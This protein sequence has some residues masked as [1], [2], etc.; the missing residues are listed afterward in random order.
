MEKMV[1]V[2]LKMQ[3]RAWNWFCL[4]LKMV[5]IS[6]FTNLE[7]LCVVISRLFFLLLSLC[8]LLFSRLF[9]VLTLEE[10]LRERKGMNDFLSQNLPAV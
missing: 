10:P 2:Q 1:I 9:Q 7:I 3:K 8:Y 5:S 4:K 6:I